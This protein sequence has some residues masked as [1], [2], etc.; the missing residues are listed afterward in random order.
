MTDEHKRKFKGVWIPR[1]IWLNKSLS[2]TEKCLLT[3]V[4]S[5]DN[6]NGCTAGNSYFASFFGVGSRQI[7]KYISA[8]ESKHLIKVSLI[9]RN[10]RRI[11][12][13]QK[14]HHERTKVPSADRTK[15]PHSN[16][17]ESNTVVPPATD[18]AREWSR[19]E[20][21]AYLDSMLESTNRATRIIA[22]FLTWKG[23]GVTGS[24]IQLKNKEQAQAEIRRHLRAANA[25]RAYTDEQVERTLE[26]L[27]THAQFAWTLETVGK[28]MNYD[29]GKLVELLKKIK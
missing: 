24:T 23:V 2:L 21:K 18:V 12:M 28:Y 5:L 26:A 8:L 29:N 10:R 9:G 27:S 3:E 17:G 13:E 25:L 19:N 11:L 16:T 7:S 6:E 22:L 4:D 15:V 20:L 14:F 1:E